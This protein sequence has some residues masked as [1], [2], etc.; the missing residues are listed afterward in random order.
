MQERLLQFIWQEKYYNSLDLYTET[1]ETLIILD[2]GTFNSH[3]GP[4][5]LNARIL[6]NGIYWAG[7]VELHIKSSHWYQHRHA[8]DPNYRNVI[9]HVVWEDDEQVLSRTLPTLV[10]QNRVP[11]MML[12]RYQFLM[13]QSS[14]IACQEQL[15]QVNA[16]TWSGWKTELLTRRLR[17]KA[18]Q[19]L[20]LLKDAGNHWDECNWWWIARH[21]GG[22]VNA[23]F[24][25]QV[26]RS[27]ETKLLARHRNQVIRLEALLLG[28]ANMLEA[29]NGDP[30]VQLLDREFRFLR[31]K[32]QLNPV[33]GQVQHLRM[34]PA[35]FPGVRL[36][37]LSMLLHQTPQLYQHLVECNS[38]RELE[39]ILDVTANDFWH[40][41]YSLDEARTYQPKHLGTEMSHQLIINAVI[42]L[43]YAVGQRH[44]QP[45]LQ[46][47]VINWLTEMAAEKNQLISGWD[48]AGVTALNAAET[49][50]LT[51]LKKSY[52]T[53]KRCLECQIGHHLLNR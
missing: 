25:E 6:L 27:I 34:R 41:H 43:I 51:E 15:H 35:G 52:C 3:Q 4:D 2:A 19:V 13:Q 24:F 8:P 22:P 48:R 18:S 1:G 37:Q 53:V 40:Y 36:A 38:L 23:V 46:Q 42:P 50:A 39:K 47:R 49:Q 9:L 33:H 30:Y 17:R 26:A 32:H 29:N 31:N 21:F 11:S 28:Q 7:Q 12:D 5:F 16:A 14:G 10:L 45:Q 20:Q 44:Q